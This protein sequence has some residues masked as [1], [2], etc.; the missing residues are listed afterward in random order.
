MIIKELLRVG[1]VVTLKGNPEHPITIID[2]KA[3]SILEESG[4]RMPDGWVLCTWIY[5]GKPHTASFPEDALVKVADTRAQEEV[6]ALAGAAEHVSQ[7]LASKMR[8]CD[9]L[10]RLATH[11]SADRMSAID[12]AAKT[13]PEKRAETSHEAVEILA[14]RYEILKK[15]A[16]EIINRLMSQLPH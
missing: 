10:R 7:E 13:Y 14:E 3:S 16:N 11:L 9:E 4:V 15:E 6:Q 1:D 5:D 8:E 2:S 12:L